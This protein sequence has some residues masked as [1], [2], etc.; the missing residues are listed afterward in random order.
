M[1]ANYDSS[2]NGALY[3]RVDRIAI[4]YSTPLTA[5]IRANET[6]AVKAADGTVY[7]VR[8]ERTLAIDVAP[9]D[10]GTVLQLRDPTT[11]AAIPG[12][13]MTVQQLMLGMLAFLRVEQ[14]RLD[15]AE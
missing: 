10:F 15:A 7:K 2:A 14:L 6:T 8:D 12:A 5:Q 13:T 1:S 9:T 4:E 11:G 3:R